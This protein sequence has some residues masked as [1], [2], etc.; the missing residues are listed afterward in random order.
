MKR[1]L[2]GLLALFPCL[3]HAQLAVIE[4]SDTTLLSGSM[5][6]TE[7]QLLDK[8]TYNQ[9]GIAVYDDPTIKEKA[10]LQLLLADGTSYFLVVEPG[11]TQRIKFTRGKGGKLQVDYKGAN[12]ALSVLFNEFAKFVPEKNTGY[13]MANQSTDTITHEEARRRLDMRYQ[14]LVKMAEKLETPAERADNLRDINLAYLANR[15]QLTADEDYKYGRNPN[16]DARYMTLIKQINP[17]DSMYLQRGLIDMFVL[18]K[19]PLATQETSIGAYGAAYLT[20]VDAYIANPKIRNELMESMVG[21]VLGQIPA[22]QTDAFWT[23]VKAKADSNII[24]KYEFVVSSRKA[25]KRGMKC[26]DVTFSDPEGQQHRLSDYFGKTL[27]IDLWATWCVPC[28]MEIPALARQ[29]EHYKN[30]ARVMFISIS[31]DK[32]R[33]SWLAK[34]QKDRPAWPQFITNSEEDALISR[35]FGVMSIPRFLLIKADGTILDA[36]AFRPSDPK[37]SEKLDALLE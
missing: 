16:K 5:L 11:K 15:L 7:A 18:S 1:I 10:Q 9:K 35:E 25:T 21:T 19:M 13:E 27:Y 8:L 33:Q 24:R 4:T 28:M 17:N 34:L 12:T 23:V 32:N 6:M 2:I 37:F 22:D 31:M 36:D 3:V 29:V 14:R 30:D 20:A 26:P